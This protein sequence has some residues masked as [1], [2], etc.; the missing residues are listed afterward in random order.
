MRIEKKLEDTYTAC[1]VEGMFTPQADLKPDQI[2]SMLN[3]ALADHES[4]KEWQKTAPKDSKQWNAIYK[5]AY[6]VLHSLSEALI[7]FDK[8]KAQSHE[9]VFAYLCEKHPELELDWNFFERARTARN[10]SV[11]Y[12][13]PISYN[14]WKESEL[15]MNLYIATLK[16]E[17]EKRLDGHQDD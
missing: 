11:Y 13:E 9:C 3:L 10:R 8:I 14:Q 4:V 17:I 16:K 12:G 5:L 2:R 1:M 7:R 6:D 15:Q